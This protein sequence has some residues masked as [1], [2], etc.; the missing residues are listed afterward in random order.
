MCRSLQAEQSLAFERL[1][2]G[3]WQSRQ[4]GRIMI[5]IL[6]T[7]APGDEVIRG[8]WGKSTTDGSLSE[9]ARTF[10][11]A[12]F[13]CTGPTGPTGEAAGPSLC[14]PGDFRTVG[15][16]ELACPCRT[17]TLRGEVRPRCWLLLP[18][19]RGGVVNPISLLTAWRRRLGPIA[20]PPKE[21][22]RALTQGLAAEQRS[23]DDREHYDDGGVRNPV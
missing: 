2:A 18:A 19:W 9:P 10:S 4:F 6:K 23:R 16:P 7:I 5:A 14:F 21:A 20:E 3:I 8:R 13:D 12:V 22:K 17:V 1:S 15:F 11:V